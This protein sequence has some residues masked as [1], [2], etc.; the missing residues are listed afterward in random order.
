MSIDLKQLEINVNL[1]ALEPNFFNNELHYVIAT[2]DNNF[3][4]STW[5][6]EPE[7]DEK[8]FYCYLTEEPLHIPAGNIDLK[9]SYVLRSEPIYPIASSAEDLA[10][11]IDKV[12][13]DHSAKCIRR[14][15]DQQSEVI[16]SQLEE[17]YGTIEKHV[18]TS[19]QGQH[20]LLV[21]DEIEMSISATMVY[22]RNKAPI[23][24]SHYEN[25]KEEGKEE[26]NQS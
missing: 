21:F 4:F 8:K 16:K 6:E 5:D 10:P 17:K 7:D 12:K 24:Q 3:R 13:N 14:F 9:Q 20:Q 11:V 23:S 19:R 26:V 22:L 15:S 2:D 1:F 25:V 18:V